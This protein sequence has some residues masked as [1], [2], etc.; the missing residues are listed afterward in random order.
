MP[1]FCVTFEEVNYYEVVVE[2]D[3]E[4]EATEKATEK[5]CND[6]HEAFFISCAEREISNIEEVGN[7]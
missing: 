3:S 2:A 1:K 4:E 7:G 6:D 5:L